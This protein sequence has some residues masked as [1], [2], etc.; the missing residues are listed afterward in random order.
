MDIY[1][2]IGIGLIGVILV[3]ILKSAKSELAFFCIVG[4]G[5]VMLVY[6]LTSLTGVVE[7]FSTIINKTGIDGGIFSGVL[8]VI[9]IGYVAEYS[10]GL[11]N[12]AGCSGIGSKILLG[13]KIAIFV[14]SLPVLEKLIDLV[15]KLVP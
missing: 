8:K 3:Q 2:L 12:D 6:I 4:V 14:I 15:I 5:I 11:C 13:G 1:K 10:A 9:G 7:I